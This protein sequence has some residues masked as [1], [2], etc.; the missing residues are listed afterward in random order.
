M[1][2]IGNLL[3]LLYLEHIFF[4]LL[5]SLYVLPDF[6]HGFVYIFFKSISMFIIA[7]LKSWLCASFVLHLSG[8]TLIGLIGTS[9][10]MTLMLL[11]VFLHC[12]LGIWF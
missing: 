7:I 12:H 5:F 8:P 1:F 6:I 9:G 3:L 2:S 11:I 10:V 4:I